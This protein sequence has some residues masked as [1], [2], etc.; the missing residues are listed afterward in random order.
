MHSPGPALTEQGRGFVFP[1]P[2]FGREA[3]PSEATLPLPQ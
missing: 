3:L 2:P 1:P